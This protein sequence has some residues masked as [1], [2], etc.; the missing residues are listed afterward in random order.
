MVDVFACCRNDDYAAVGGLTETNK[1]DVL[2]NPALCG[3]MTVLAKL[4]D[5]AAEHNRNVGNISSTEMQKL[6]KVTMTAL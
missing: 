3:K 6:S 5:R 2:S 4:I 1:H